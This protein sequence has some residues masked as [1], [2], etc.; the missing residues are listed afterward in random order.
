[1][2]KQPVL[3]LCPIGKFVF[4][5]KDA[6]RHKEIIRGKLRAWK[7]DF[8]DIDAAVKDGMIRSQEDVEPAVRC[9]RSQGID[10]L[11]IPHC[12]FGTEG[13]AGVIA[14]DLGLP[15]LLWGPRDEKPLADGTRLR[16]SLCGLFAT[17]KVLHKLKVPFTYIEN[18][19][20]EEEPF[21][22]G[23]LDFMRAARVV[24]RMRR[25]RIGQI[26]QRIDFFWTT[27][28]NESELL[29]RFGVE[30]LPLDMVDFV[31]A[32]KALARAR[33]TRYL[34]EIKAGRDK[35][36]FKGFKNREPVVNMF[37]MRDHML[38]LA[39]DKRLDTFAVQSFSSICD[40]LG[41]MVEYACAM[42]ADAG[43]PVA[44]ETDIHGAISSAM[45]AA[46]AEDREPIIFADLTIRHPTNDNAILIWHCG[47]PEGVCDPTSKPAVGTHWILPGIQPGSCHWRLKDGDLTVF[48]FDSDGGVYEAI[49]GEGRTVPGPFTQNTYVWMEVADWPAWERAFIE[50]PYI[51]HVACCYGRHAAIL[52]EACRY[53]PGLAITMLP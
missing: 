36:A 18:C 42:V 5:H 50:G 38:A 32:V 34:A 44:C 29:E 17:S 14:R 53:L 12:N 52:K 31:K 10:A 4:S 45:L 47:F 2:N 7:V 26:G 15:T 43:V 35:P 28:V 16:D 8:R 48:R 25:L 41:C 20:P 40:E 11:F 13:A 19:R 49:A 30:V 3:G 1:M 46:A 22:R 6:M 39:R 24:K 51:H 9:L 27:I 21:R 33:R 37:A 23:V